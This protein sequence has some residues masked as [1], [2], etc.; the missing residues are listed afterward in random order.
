MKWKKFVALSI[1]LPII[2]GLLFSSPFIYNWQRNKD[3]VE[4]R[5]EER[6]NIGVPSEIEKATDSLMRTLVD[7]EFIPAILQ[8]FGFAF[9]ITLFGLA[10]WFI[11][12][13]PNKNLYKG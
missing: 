13:N 2:V 3:L 5:I 1:I 9:G 8:A 11:W 10:L 6:N 4:Q 12:V 7:A